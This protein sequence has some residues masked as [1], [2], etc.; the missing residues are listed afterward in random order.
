MKFT[1]I[2]GRWDASG[3]ENISVLDSVSTHT[4]DLRIRSSLEALELSLAMLANVDDYPL[5]RLEMELGG[6]RFSLQ[7]IPDHEDPEREFIVISG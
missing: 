3:E 1:V 2:A 6:H 7:E 5:V 4:G